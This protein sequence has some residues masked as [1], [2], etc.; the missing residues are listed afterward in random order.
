MGKKYDKT[1]VERHRMDSGYMGMISEDRSAPA[2]L[3]QQVV[4]KYYP[5]GDV[6]NN[7]YLDD[8]IKGVDD[9]IR[10]SVKKVASNQSDSMY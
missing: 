1:G 6:I 3:P 5:K 10:D 7:Y 4:H 2:N 9:T 8:T